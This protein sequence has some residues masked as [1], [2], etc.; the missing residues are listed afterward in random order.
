MVKIKNKLL[1]LNLSCLA[2]RFC[3]R[4]LLLKTPTIQFKLLSTCEPG[5]WG[6]RSERENG[7]FHFE[8]NVF[9]L[10]PGF[11]KKIYFTDVIF[12]TMN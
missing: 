8:W 3:M 9:I 1:S 4:P 12:I 11:L 2:K 10:I 6:D 5:T 7:L